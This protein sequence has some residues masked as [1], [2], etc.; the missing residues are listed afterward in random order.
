MNTHT[1]K[2]A[3]PQ[4]NDSDTQYFLLAIGLSI[5]MHFMVMRLIPLMEKYEPKPPVDIVA[6]LLTM[7][8]PP[9]PPVMA[10]STPAEETPVRPIEKQVQ[11][12]PKAVTTKPD[13]ILTSKSAEAPSDYAVPDTPRA[14]EINKVPS[15]PVVSA[16]APAETSNT[17]QTSASSK[18]TS[19][20]NTASDW[21]DSDLW[22]EYGNNLQRLCERNKKYPEIARRRG[23]QGLAKV[24]VHFSAEG[25]PL[26]IV[27][28]SSSGQASLDDQAV[29]MVK[30][31]IKEL[32]LPNK[33]RGRDFKISI[34]IDF[35]LDI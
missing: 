28:E 22:D 35:K 12:E 8:P 20:S 1:Y 19:S 29:E 11:K 5:A 14:E 34:P 9:P 16:P 30:K 31:S 3:Y 18:N 13:P 24:A 21:S 26:S 17:E 27:I 4:P 2:Q 25:K 15:A 6:E 23:L 10:E 33:F 7:A 32:P